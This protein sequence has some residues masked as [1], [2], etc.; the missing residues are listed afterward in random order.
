MRKSVPKVI[1]IVNLD[2]YQHYKSRHMVWF[3]WYIDCLQ[4]H[5]FMEMKEKEKWIFIGLMCLACKAN[6]EIV[7][8][9]R[10]LERTLNTDR[11]SL[12]IDYLK[13][14]GMIEV[15]YQDAIPIREDKIREEKKREEKRR[16]EN[17]GIKDPSHEGKSLTTDERA[18][19]MKIM[20]DLKIKQD[21][22]DKNLSK[23]L[24]HV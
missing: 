14:I 19:A 5:K 21:A 13:S 20:R 24:K 18:K 23:E 9:S 15:C 10:W 4:D 16:E 7:Y 6:N 17:K 1:K 2:R 12:S 3:K 11:I 22:R 8:D